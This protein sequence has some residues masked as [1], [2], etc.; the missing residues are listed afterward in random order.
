MFLEGG[1]GSGA[2]RA[3][4]SQSKRLGASLKQNQFS[5]QPASTPRLM[6]GLGVSSALAGK[7]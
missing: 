4:V 6:S 5:Q 1:D 2:V 3:P 7:I